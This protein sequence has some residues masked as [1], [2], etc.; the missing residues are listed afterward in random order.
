MDGDHGMWNR[1]D[2]AIHVGEGAQ[3]V[4]RFAGEGH[5]CPHQ[6]S[7]FPSRVWSSDA[8]YLNQ[9][10]LECCSL[11]SNGL[12]VRAQFMISC[13]AANKSAI[14]QCLH[15]CMGATCHVNWALGRVWFEAIL[16]VFLIWWYSAFC[17]LGPQL[18]SNLLCNCAYYYYVQGFYHHHSLHPLIMRIQTYLYWRKQVPPLHKAAL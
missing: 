13:Q 9:L 1:V 10:Q 12:V 4:R 2:K 7:V 17:L 18:Q 11:H 15:F 5:I 6:N 16:Q 3:E 8:Q 14:V